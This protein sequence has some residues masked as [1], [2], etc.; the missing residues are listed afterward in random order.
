MTLI[1]AVGENGLEVPVGGKVVIGEVFDRV[2]RPSAEV[3]AQRIAASGQGVQE[4]FEGDQ[5]GHVFG[6]RFVLAQ[7]LRN[8]FA[9]DGH[10][11]MVP[12]R[13]MENEWSDFARYGA[14]VEV[15][16]DLDAPVV[17]E[18]SDVISVRGK[19]YSARSNVLLQKVKINDT[20]R[21]DSSQQYKRQYFKKEILAM[22][23][24]AERG[25]S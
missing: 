8:M 13:V 2:D 1:T 16:I 7:G 21:N 14:R 5:G 11:N 3:S 15:E 12:Y 6:F 23:A 20:F 18:R 25:E 9:Q 22:V 17:G 10:F 24:A 4:V 19:A